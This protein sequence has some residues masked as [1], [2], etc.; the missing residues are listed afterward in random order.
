MK[1]KTLDGMMH[2]CDFYATFCYLAGAIN[3]NDNA[4][5]PSPIDSINFWPYI[6]GQVKESPRSLIVHDHRMY[7][8]TTE[9]AIRNGK[10]K[11]V[12]MNESAAGWYGQFTPNTSWNNSMEQIYACSVDKPCLFDIEADVTEHNDISSENPDI[13]KS[14]VELFNSFDKEYHPPK[15]H[16]TPEQE[17]FCNAAQAAGEFAVP[18]QK[19]TK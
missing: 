2:I 18:W 15:N 7:T 3:P 17:A 10:Y 14:M 16:P 5:A 12:M 8:S 1:G 9:G 6:S 11:L 13:V 4:T 19:G